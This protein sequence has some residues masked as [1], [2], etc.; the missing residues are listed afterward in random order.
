MFEYFRRSA[1]VKAKTAEYIRKNPILSTCLQTLLDHSRKGGMIYCAGDRESR[2]STDHFCEELQVCF[3]GGKALGR[4]SRGA[5]AAVSLSAYE[6]ARVAALQRNSLQENDALVVFSAGSDLLPIA[7]FAAIAEARKIL[8]II[9]GRGVSIIK[10]SAVLLP[11]PIEADDNG[12]LFS[13]QRTALHALCEPF[14]PEYKSDTHYLLD[15]F[16]KAAQLDQ[17][18]ASNEEFGALCE[19]AKAALRN[20]L[21]A[22]S[23][24]YTFGNGGSACDADEIA[25][26]FQKQSDSL[27][28]PI[29]AMS[30][31]QAGY[32]TCAV[33]DGFAIFRRGVE[34]MRNKSGVIIALSTSGNSSNVIEATAFA[35]K[36]GILTIGL[37]G[38]GGGK[39][40]AEV[41]FP[42]VVP[43]KVTERIQE[44]HTLIGFW[45]AS[46]L[47]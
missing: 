6:P 7:E 8:T 25:S 15:V 29:V 23:A 9:I 3:R 19:K 1:E 34:A 28:R 37:I 30:L 16:E 38:K 22:G 47:R 20:S 13:A 31:L 43:S 32:L 12:I 4:E 5:V 17:E 42:L 11:I 46:S 41:D 24:V 27:S 36:K 39:M 40:T 21:T 33:N 2:F 10:P 26:E 14:E 35:R 44:V 45:L 18:I